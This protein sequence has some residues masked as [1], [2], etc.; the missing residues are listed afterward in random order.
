MKYIVYIFVFMFS[1]S[2]LAQR[3]RP[4]IGGIV[5]LHGDFEK[6][7]FGNFSLGSEIKV[8]KFFRAEIEVSYMFG[9][10][11]DAVSRD[12]KGITMSVSEKSASAMNYSFCPKIVIGDY[13]EDSGYIQ[14]L[15]RYT[16]SRIEAK[17][18]LTSRNPADLSKPIKE[19]KNASDTQHSLGIGVGYIYNF[20]GE[21]Q[22]SIGFNLYYNGVDLG[23]ALNKLKTNPDSYN[24]STKDVI[25]FG[26]NFYLGL[27]KKK[28]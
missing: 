3:V 23:N 2:I 9:R 1:V 14:I 27:K 28:G 15:P 12:E 8:V 19:R 6:S 17:K 5:Y 20:P 22:N 18:E 7:T 4:F 10:L 24:Y 13:E 26:I 25:G 16:F 11:E 21:Y